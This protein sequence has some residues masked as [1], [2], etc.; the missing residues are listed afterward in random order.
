MIVQITLEPI[1]STNVRKFKEIGNGELDCNDRVVRNFEVANGSRKTKKSKITKNFT[2]TVFLIREAWATF[3]RL[4][5]TFI[6]APILDYFDSKYP[7][8][9][10]TN[11]FD[12]VISKVLN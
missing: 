6:E 7:I 10:E 12:F 1:S 4:Q 2:R 5:N 11:V 8:R 3:T 9:I